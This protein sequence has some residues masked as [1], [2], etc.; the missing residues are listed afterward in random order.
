MDHVVK[1]IADKTP[2]ISFSPVQQRLA[3][4]SAASWFKLCM[5]THCVTFPVH[6]GK[7]PERPRDTNT[8]TCL[9]ISMVILH[10]LTVCMLITSSFIY[11]S[12]S[13]ERELKSEEKERERLEE[14]QKRERAS[15][16]QQSVKVRNEGKERKNKFM[17]DLLNSN[18]STPTPTHTHTPQPFSM[19]AQ[20][21]QHTAGRH[22][23]TKGPVPLQNRLLPVLIGCQVCSSP[24]VV[25]VLVTMVTVM[26]VS[27]Q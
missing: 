23:R 2:L 19:E 9:N 20:R 11:N 14:G 15:C 25:S 6:A 1:L 7:L 27:L 3:R 4:P 24:G 22:L 10:I 13:R 5:N 17:C 26:Q 12:C 18:H 16:R 21:A 8:H